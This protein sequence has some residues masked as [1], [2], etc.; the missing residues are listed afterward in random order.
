MYIFGVL[1]F[2]IFCV[3]E[4]KL[5]NIQF[6]SHLSLKIVIR[7]IRKFFSMA[8]ILNIFCGI[9]TQQQNKNSL[10]QRNY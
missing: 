3:Y 5:F 1:C 2:Y 4:M 10:S 6:Q 8:F 9:V 7:F